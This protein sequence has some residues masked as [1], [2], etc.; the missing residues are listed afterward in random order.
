MGTIGEL[1]MAAAGAATILGIGQKKQDKRQI[2]QQTKLQELQIKGQKELADYQQQQQMDMWH[3]TNYDA[4]KK[5]IEKAGLNP[6]LLYGTSG[7]GGTTTGAGI[8]GGVSG[9][10]AANS[11]QTSQANIAMGM[12]LAQLE[13]MKAQTE[14]TKAEADKISGIDTQKA[15]AEA[16]NTEFHNQLNKMIGIDSMAGAAI[17]ANEKIEIESQR[18]NAE[19]ESYLAAGYKGKTFD[20]PNSPIAKAMTAGWEKSLEELKQAKLNN[21]AT[22]AGNIVKKFEAKLAEQGIHPQSPWWTKLITD[23]LEKTGI[24]NI[25]GTGQKEIKQE[26]KN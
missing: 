7:G 23:M 18:A 11:A 21:D 2:N 26:I 20:D 24:T 17:A 5:E 4:Q 1:G 13:L 9:G 8:A 15:T 10:D 22:E 12:Q 6:A 14:K 25:I 16:T 3:N 19:W